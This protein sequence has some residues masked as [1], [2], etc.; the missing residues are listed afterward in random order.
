MN[1][2]HDRQLVVREYTEL[3]LCAMTMSTAGSTVIHCPHAPLIVVMLSSTAA[4]LGAQQADSIVETPWRGRVHLGFAGKDTAGSDYGPGGVS[5]G[6]TVGH[7]L[8][9]GMMA[10]ADVVYLRFGGRRIRLLC[11]GFGCSY[12]PPLAPD[13]FRQIAVTTG[14]EWRPWRRGPYAGGAGAVAVTW[15]SQVVEEGVAPGA[16]L[17]VGWRFFE[18]VSLEYQFIWLLGRPRGENA[19]VSLSLVIGP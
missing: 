18:L 7:E 10:R 12:S 4:G 5:F 13:S 9:F 2:S 16:A 17:A 6:F 3:V 14:I 8:G 11:T 15:G 19:T 1:R